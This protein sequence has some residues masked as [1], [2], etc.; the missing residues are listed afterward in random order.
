[1]ASV[2]LIRAVFLFGACGALVA[3]GCGQETRTVSTS[4]A[5]AT[6]TPA[7][8]TPKPAVP[9]T[10]GAPSSRKTSPAPAATSQVGPATIYTS[11]VQVYAQRLIAADAARSKTCGT[12][13]VAG[14]RSALQQTADAVATFQRS[15]DQHP[16]PPCLKTP[17]STIRVALSLYQQGAQLGLKGLSDGSASEVSQADGLIEQATMRLNAA[18][19][20]MQAVAVCRGG[21]PGVPP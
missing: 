12:S 15:L 18:A 3:S 4:D 17:D 8:H 10:P 11:G 5:Q 21:L 16:A 19:E 13:D 14:C 9:Q 2:G 7:R 1:M 6:A 20:Q